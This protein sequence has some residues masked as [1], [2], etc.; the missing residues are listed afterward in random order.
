MLSVV[1]G[2]CL[3]LDYCTRMMKLTRVMRE[4]L[5]DMDGYG[6]PFSAS[7]NVMLEQ[8]MSPPACLS[9]G[10]FVLY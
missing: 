1:A 10:Y 7:L 5:V 9:V 3:E 6:L 8:V 4:T 2:V